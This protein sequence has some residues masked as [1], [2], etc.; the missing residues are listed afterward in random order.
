MC[1]VKGM[2]NKRRLTSNDP[3]YSLDGMINPTFTNV[4]V[5]SVY[6]DEELIATGESFKIDA[7]GILL[8]GKIAINFTSSVVTERNL[9][10]R[11]V[12]PV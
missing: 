6:I 5:S 7:P 4:G 9:V 12:S 10:L 2:L 3:G 11:F 1:L 8:T